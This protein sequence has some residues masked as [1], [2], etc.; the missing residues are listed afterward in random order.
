M[1]CQPPALIVFLGAERRALEILKEKQ[2]LF[3]EGTLDLL[4]RL[5]VVALKVDG[6]EQPH[7]AGR[8]AL[9]RPAFLATL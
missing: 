9:L 8:L 6:S 3:V 2:R 7:Q 5:G 4:R 1:V